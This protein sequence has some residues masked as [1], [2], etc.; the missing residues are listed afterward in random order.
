MATTSAPPLGLMPRS[1]HNQHRAQEIVAAMDR[2]IDASKKIPRAWIEELMEI[3][4]E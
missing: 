4:S 2:Y 3:Y 1:I